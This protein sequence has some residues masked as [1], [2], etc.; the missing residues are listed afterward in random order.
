MPTIQQLS[1]ATSFSPTDELVVAQG[2]AT[3]A[4]A[5]G[6]LLQGVQPVIALSPGALLGRCSAGD[7]PI[8]LVVPGVGLQQG[9]GNLVAT[10]L[11]HLGYGVL[12]GLAGVS[13]VIVNANAL[14]ARLPV[15]LLRGL[16]NGSSTVTLDATGT[17]HSVQFRYG[18][19][20]P[21]ATLGA[22]GDSYL[23]VNSGEL[24]S[25]GAAGWLDSGI[26]ILAPEAAAR[27]AALAPL[28]ALSGQSTGLVPLVLADSAALG[29]P[30]G[31]SLVRLTGSI[32]AQDQLSGDASV[33]D[34]ACVLRAA[35]PGL[36]YSLV[37]APAITVFAQDADM[38]GCTVSIATTSGVQLLVAGI[39]GRQIE[40]SATLLKVI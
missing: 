26:N 25:N 31:R 28:I 14:P 23:D 35:A 13:E 17:I 10:G 36:A 12:A 22:V 21:A 8:E 18:V 34:F 24:W 39:A 9:G 7:G 20:A 15:G 27:S 32:T 16:F 40:W 3:N 38:A 29:L 33:W 6:T 2:T 19:G 11:D 37:G 30:G 4:L 1:V 5:I